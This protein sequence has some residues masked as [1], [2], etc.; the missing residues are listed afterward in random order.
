M[1]LVKRSSSYPAGLA[2]NYGALGKNDKK[3][4]SCDSFKLFKINREKC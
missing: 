1:N 4:L 3:S 2:L